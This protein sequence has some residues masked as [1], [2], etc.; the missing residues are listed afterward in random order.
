[1]PVGRGGGGHGYF[2]LYFFI[3]RL[4][5]YS[6]IYFFVCVCPQSPY[7]GNDIISWIFPIVS[8]HAFCM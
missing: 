5:F 4:C 7:R 1:M 8:C 6:F 3:K 2:F